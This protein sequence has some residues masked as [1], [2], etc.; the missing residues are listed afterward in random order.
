[1][2]VALQHGPHEVCRSAKPATNPD[3][4]THSLAVSSRQTWLHRGLDHNMQPV[5]CVGSL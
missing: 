1:M 5:C 2:T 3:L 4:F